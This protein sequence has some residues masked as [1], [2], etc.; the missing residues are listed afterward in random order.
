[1][2]QGARRPLWFFREKE[3]CMT[4]KEQSVGEII[5]SR[6]TRCRIVTNHTIVAMVGTEVVKVKCNTCDGMHKYHAPKEKKVAETTAAPKKAAVPGARKAANTARVQQEE[7]VDFARTAD[8]GSSVPYDMNARYKVG[9]LVSHPS[10]GIGVV[11]ELI[12]P[13]KVDI[14]FQDGLKRLRCNF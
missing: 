6:C 7:W 14:L 9:V 2:P 11:K 1:M 8:A 4:K 12:K 10:F 13:N 5:D 3:V